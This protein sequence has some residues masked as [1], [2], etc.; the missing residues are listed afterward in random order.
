MG[1]TART[2]SRKLILH[3]LSPTTS[4]TSQISKFETADHNQKSEAT[5]RYTH[6]TT[7]PFSSH[8][9]SRHRIQSLFD[10]V[11]IKMATAPSHVRNMTWR[12][13]VWLTFVIGCHLLLPSTC[14][15]ILPNL[16][17]QRFAFQPSILNYCLAGTIYQLRSPSDFSSE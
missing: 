12:R 8:H 11:E 7:L 17:G 10:S 6:I 15:S 1:H 3:S 5:Y 14:F 9:K 2:S 16:F 13:R 4:G